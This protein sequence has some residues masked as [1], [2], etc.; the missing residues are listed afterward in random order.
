MKKIYLFFITALA[1]LGMTSCQ[2]DDLEGNVGYLR[3]EVGT[4]AYVD[5]RIADEY[6][7]K[8]IALQIVNSKDEV[9]E[10]TDDWETLSGKQIRLA[11][12]TYTVKASSNGFDGSE[13]GFDIPYYAGS[14]QITVQ[15]GKEVTANI[16]CTLANVKVTVNYD[17]SFIDAFQSATATVKSAQEGVGE[18]SFK[19]GD[20]LKSGYFPVADLTA[21]ISVVN[22][23]GKSFSQATPINDVKAR[24]HYILNFKVAESG[25]IEKPSVTV[26][27]S[28]IIYTFTFNVSTEAATKL[29]VEQANAWSYF[30]YV[31]GSVE[32]VEEGTELDAANMTFE[33]K[34]ASEEVWRSIEAQADGENAFKATLVD[35]QPG[36]QYSYRMA[37]NGGGDA[38]F[39]SDAVNFTTETASL[40]PN[41]DMDDWYKSG[42]TWYPVSESD[43]AASGSFWD[44]SNP[45][46]TTGAGALVNVNPTQGNSEI[47]HTSGGKSAE[48][49]SQYASAFGIGKFAA[50][51]LYTG[52]F[53]SL[54]GTNGAKIDFGQKFTSR[55]SALHGWFQYTSGKIDYRGNN[56]P[57]GV[58]EIDTDD[59]CSIYI[60]LAKAPHQLDNTQTSTFFDFEN[61]DNI[62]AYGELP[63]SEAMSTNNQWKEFNVKLKYKDITPQAEYYL[64]IVCSSSKYGDYFTGSTGSTMYIDDMELIYETPAVR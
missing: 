3:I 41:G 37:Y 10:S 59:L 6:N 35:L 26:D 27:G 53:N 38:N 20:E 61:D 28:E 51:S 60:A 52:K 34:A 24:K 58:A 5:T 46:T 14:Q 12:G 44:S 32:S 29:S 23:A 57:E 30:A 62:I 9:V 43:Y 48:L 54:V 56:T 63:D 33:Y 8:Q 42:K 39:K 45:G 4:N 22:H 13:S 17:Q 50:A 55:P 40:L 7:P 19:M 36:T 1:V 47:V 2:Q 16:T 15:T 25:S 64:I 49:K 11:A 18:L 31:R 21:T